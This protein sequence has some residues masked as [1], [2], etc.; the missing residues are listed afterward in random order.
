MTIRLAT[1]AAATALTACSGEQAGPPASQQ[2]PDF[3]ARSADL[4]QEMSV[5]T[6]EP[7][8]RITT[9]LQLS[10]S[11]PGTWYFEGSFPIRLQSADGET[12]AQSVANSTEDWMTE[13]PVAF[14]ASLDFSVSAPTEATLVLSEDDPSGRGNVQEA[15][16]P[17]VLLPRK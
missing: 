1:I 15:H 10:G 2:D 13:E 16:L 17:V 4:P 9:P 3:A 12:L 14:E 6:P 11:V 8:A 5:E 7:N